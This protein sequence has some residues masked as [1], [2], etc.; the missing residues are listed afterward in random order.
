MGEVGETRKARGS[1]LPILPCLPLVPRGLTLHGSQM[2][3]EMPAVV[4]K[5]APA[6]DLALCLRHIAC[7]P[8]V[9][10]YKGESSVAL[11]AF[12][13][14]QDLRDSTTLAVLDHLPNHFFLEGSLSSHTSEAPPIYSRELSAGSNTPGC[15]ASRIVAPFPS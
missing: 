1:T 12:S 15:S 4:A 2:K 6:R 13:C 11:V 7:P 10:V 9:R 14:L 8:E 5:A 3:V